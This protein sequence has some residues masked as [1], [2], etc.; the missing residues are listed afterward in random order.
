MRRSGLAVAALLAVGLLPVAASSSTGSVRAAATA[1]SGAIRV[2]RTRQPVKFIAADGSRVAV[3]TTTEMENVCDR[4]VVWSPRKRSSVSFKTG[5]C[6][7][8]STID[9]IWG[10]ALAGKTAMWLEAGGGNWIELGVFSHTLGS[11]KTKLVSPSASYSLSA[12]ESYEYGPYTFLGNVFG[13]GNLLVFNSWTAC[14]EVPDGW[15]GAT[16]SQS[17]PGSAPVM[18]YSDQKL[19]KVVKG[20]GVEIASAPNTHIGVTGS[21]SVEGPS[22]A[23]AVAPAVV[24]VDAKRIAAQNPDGSVTIYSAKGAVLRSIHVPSGTFSGFALQGSQLVTIRN[25]KLE[26]YSVSTGKLVKAIPVPGGS[27]LGGLEKGLVTYVDYRIHVLRLSDR[28]DVTF[29]SP[30]SDFVNARID[31][32][33]LVYAYNTTGHAPGRV[34]FVPYAKVLKK[35]G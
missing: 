26:L 16:C 8:V 32:S 18:L 33:G 30:R 3:A 5:V 23:V 14:M 20:K 11:K 6:N 9:D 2:L 15:D 19:L 17:A 25:N 4:V 29:S 12:Y 7:D 28:K 1:S 35:L 10:L 34:V 31:T 24:A 21:V 27:Q 22:V 13:A